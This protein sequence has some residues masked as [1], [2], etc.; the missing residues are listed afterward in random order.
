MTTEPK[1][2]F[3]VELLDTEPQEVQNPYSGEKVTLNPVALAVHDT[4]KGAEMWRDYRTMQI[5]LDW[6]KEHYP[7]EYMV[8][9][10]SKGRF[11]DHT[12]DRHK[13]PT[14]KVGFFVVPKNRPLPRL[15]VPGN[16]FLT[17]PGPGGDPPPYSLLR[18]LGFTPQMA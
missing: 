16:L 12:S 18:T 6:F 15:Q 4:I 9:L 17:T 3:D 13:C 14:Q 10:V 8:L 7:K 11:L 5:G 2:P 1:P